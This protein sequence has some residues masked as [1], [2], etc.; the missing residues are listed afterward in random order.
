MF[1]WHHYLSET[2]K[3]HSVPTVGA[4]TV[5]YPEVSFLSRATKTKE[6]QLASWEALRTLLMGLLC[7]AP[8]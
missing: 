4:A 8:I 3:P 7:L 1:W 5:E 2:K 6:R